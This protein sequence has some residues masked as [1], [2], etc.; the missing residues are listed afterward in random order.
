MQGKGWAATHGFRGWEI[1]V[2]DLF[3]VVQIFEEIL[4]ISFQKQAYRVKPI[5]PMSEVNLSLLSM[6]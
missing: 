2:T 4:F 6:W 3:V 1:T 5:K